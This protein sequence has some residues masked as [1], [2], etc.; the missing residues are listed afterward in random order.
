MQTQSIDAHMGAVHATLFLNDHLYTGGNDRMIRV[1]DNACQK[2]AE[3][4][5]S[6]EVLSLCSLGGQLYSGGREGGGSGVEAAR[7]PARG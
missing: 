4:N 2:I 7:R 1:W 5:T 6:E 3:A